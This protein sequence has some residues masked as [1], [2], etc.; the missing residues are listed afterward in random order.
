MECEV[1]E[2]LVSGIHVA[3]RLGL[4]TAQFLPTWAASVQVYQLHEH[5]ALHVPLTVLAHGP[6]HA[7]GEIPAGQY[8]LPRWAVTL[9]IVD[10]EPAQSIFEFHVHV[11]G[12]CGEPFIWPADTVSE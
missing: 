4:G 7:S 12:F 1:G 5:G 11:T 9:R 8:I 6:A 10:E 2:F 3:P